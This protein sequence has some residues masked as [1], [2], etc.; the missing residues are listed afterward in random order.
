MEPN[1]TITSRVSLQNGV[2]Q[3]EILHTP[4]PKDPKPWWVHGLRLLVCT[5]LLFVCGFFDGMG[6][7]GW[8]MTL[9]IWCNPLVVSLIIL[10]I[11]L[12]NCQ[13]KIRR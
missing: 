10:Y 5:W 1:Y 12:H 13:P 3:E 6:I 2:L 7:D 4:I 11:L 8:L 9:I